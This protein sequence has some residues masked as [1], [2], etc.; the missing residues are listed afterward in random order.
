[1]NAQIGLLSQT[2]AA[3]G[4]GLLIG[5]EREYH[6]RRIGDQVKHPGAAGIRTF[7][8]IALSGNLLTWL[9]DTVMPWG[10]ALGMAFIALM[11]VFSYRRTSNETDTDPGIT[12]EIVMVVTFILGALTGLGYLLHAT[13]VAAIV[14]CLLRFKKVLHHFSHSLSKMDLTQATQFLIISAVVLPIL[15]NTTYGAYAAL[16]PQRIWL[17]VV[18][19]SGIGFAAYATIKVLGQRAGLG[20][21]GFLGGMASSTAVTLAM[22]RLSKANPALT[23]ACQLSIIVACA[24][25]FPRVTVIALLFSPEVSRLL[26]LPVAII[27][28]C[29]FA[30]A[31]WLWRQSAGD[32]GESGKYRPELNPL[33]WHV[34]LSFGAFYA[35]VL[36]LT[37]MAQ[38]EFGTGGLMSV[39]GLS[40]LSDVDAITLSVSEMSRDH[41]D[42]ALAARAILLACAANSF[43]KWLMGL[44][45]SDPSA[46]IG[47][48]LG[49]VPMALLSLAAVF[50]LGG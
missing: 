2:L 43:V 20:V 42:A 10:I 35:M 1:M 47:L 33:S 32:K 14:F 25:M 23:A 45:F 7:A 31:T 30:T 46:R 3:I 49:L 5:L 16:N 50:M 4:I 28:L 36:F 21:T 13:V 18:L 11:A 9:P 27:T 24:T 8:L 12:T 38:A 6:L 34:A 40:G 48:S 29:A 41:L 22:S 19:I 26:A 37:H 39:A 15:P 17:M 44:M